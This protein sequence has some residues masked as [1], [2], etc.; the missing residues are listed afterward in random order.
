L[1]LKSPM[2]SFSTC[3]EISLQEVQMALAS[4]KWL[5]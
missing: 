1:E 3:N 2:Q 5:L 4:A